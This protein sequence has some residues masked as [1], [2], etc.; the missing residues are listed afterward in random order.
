MGF[1]STPPPGLT[2]STLK[3]H[4]SGT[5][6]L[7]KYANAT[8]RIVNL[9]VARARWLLQRLGATALTDSLAQTEAAMVIANRNLIAAPFEPEP[10]VRVR[11]VMDA[12]AQMAWLGLRTEH[13]VSLATTIVDGQVRKAREHARLAMLL[14]L[15]LSVCGAL[16]LLASRGLALTAERARRRAVV[17]HYVGIAVLALSWFTNYRWQELQEITS[18]LSLTWYHVNYV[19]DQQ[20]YSWILRDYADAFYDTQDVISTTPDDARAAFNERERLV[21]LAW[22][23]EDLLDR[24]DM[25]DVDAVRSNM[26]THKEVLTPFLRFRNDRDRVLGGWDVDDV[27]RDSTIAHKEKRSQVAG[28]SL[29]LMEAF[30]RLRSELPAMQELCR[31][32]QVS[33]WWAFMLSYVIGTFCVVAPSVYV[34]TGRGVRGGSK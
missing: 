18:R 19:G 2:V 12:V 5:L 14:Y 8:G 21:A 22:H 13:T 28:R 31:R 9:M 17:V 20:L 1:K 24:A 15:S 30:E 16:L 4:P 10:S 32:Q 29:R 34:S 33:W 6:V 11:A 25:L 7:Q 3:V 26:A 27:G 23:A